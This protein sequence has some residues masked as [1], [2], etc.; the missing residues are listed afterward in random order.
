MAESPLLEEQRENWG[1]RTGFILA[2]IGSAVGLGNLWGFP[3]KLYTY[4]G[5]AFLIPYL[6]AM[7]IIGIPIL[8]L[9]FSLGHMTQRAAPEAYKRVGR[10]KEPIG[11][12]GIILG[13]V[14]ITY[15]PV[16]LAWC[17]GYLWFAVEG[18]V[19]H[20]G[21]L[22]FAATKEGAEG[23]F[24]SFRNSWASGEAPHPWSL[25]GIQPNLA[26]CLGIVWI[27][28]LLCIVK[29][30]RLVGKVVLW[31]VPLPWLM[32][33]ILMF[34]GLT[35]PG[36][37]R[38]M[39]YYLNPDWMQLLKPE[40]WKW[41]F[42]QV[43]FSMSLAFGVMI[44]YAS[45][46]HRKS[47][48]NNNAAIIGLGD[49]ATS[50]I[51]GIAVFSTLGAMSVATSVPVESVV[52]GG[53]DLSFIAFPYSL[54]QLPHSAWFALAFFFAL[55]TLGIDSAFSITESV[56]AS[57]VDKTGWNRS[58]T[59]WGLSFVGFGLGL[60]YC[61]RGGMSW[62]GS[63]DGFVNG[64]W[65]ISLMGLLECVVLGWAFRL[66]RL[67]EHAN[68]RSDWKLGPWWDWNIRIVVPVVLT[69]LFAWDLNA[70]ISNPTFFATS[71]GDLQYLNITS[72]CLACLAP[73]LAIALSLF[74]TRATG[75]VAE[76]Q[77]ALLK[78]VPDASGKARLAALLAAGAIL[79]S[80][81]AG[82]CVISTGYHSWTTN[83]DGQTVQSYQAARFLRH[84]IPLL[85]AIAGMVVATGLALAATGIAARRL[86]RVEAEAKR[87]T[88]AT[89]F[90][91][92]CGT[93][94]LGL[95][96]GL[97][98]SLIVLVAGLDQGGATHSDTL[99]V[100]GYIVLAL[101]LAILVFGLA[102]CFI[103]AI[104]A[105]GEDEEPQLSEE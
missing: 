12:W 25:G 74:R 7:L 105:A 56:L 46:L 64:P 18:V 81:L 22:P 89:C 34:N 62:L 83:E 15:Y 52:D 54:A 55:I 63:M 84:G 93:I 24:N 59:L 31:T 21:S 100:T 19:Y 67:R 20:G 82:I 103:R 77:P 5:G 37:A 98:L 57:L 1:S 47:D 4:G 49:L 36:A 48:I 73:L 76:G 10:K 38:G 26:L 50:F 70:K 53:P 102:W 9:E 32:L 72:V 69:V 88:A 92:M 23:F 16:I 41:A 90:A 44:T 71:E 78:P 17:L 13:F 75:S 6:L 79:L 99:S 27:L 35:Q 42:G 33:M 68:E 87:P 51:A 30:V 45:F 11:W 95:N 60:V 94:S 43:F 28:M 40:T 29:G 61:S 2:A 96:I 39:A 86:A 65:G 66:P 85:V 91:G 104:K 58:A 8:I 97:A 80:I 3:Y 101:T 14:I